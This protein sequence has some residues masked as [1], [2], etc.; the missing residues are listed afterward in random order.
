M[1]CS[2]D[3]WKKFSVL[4]KELWTDLYTRFEWANIFHSDWE[5]NKFMKQR[6]VTAHNM[7]CIAVWCCQEHFAD[8]LT[9]AL[10]SPPTQMPTKF[11]KK[12]TAKIPKGRPAAKKAANKSKAVYKK[13]TRKTS[14]I[15]KRY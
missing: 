15:K 6:E 14:K 1:K 13:A 5:D 7:A 2:L 12:V 4:E 3:I 8:T 11:G 9:K 10:I